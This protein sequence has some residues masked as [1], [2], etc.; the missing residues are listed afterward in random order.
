MDEERKRVI[1]IMAAILS[2]LHMQRADDL[3]ECRTVRRSPTALSRQAFSGRSGSCR[4]LI[5]YISN[6]VAE[7]IVQPMLS[8][9]TLLHG[10]SRQCR[11]RAASGSRVDLLPHDLSI[12]ETRRKMKMSEALISCRRVGHRLKAF[13]LGSTVC[14]KEP[15]G[16]LSGVQSVIQITDAR[17]DFTV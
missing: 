9:V 17:P 5:A 6:E 8:S 10:W 13:R 16:L 12:P 15:T 4:E 14:G 3:P 2:A 7:N 11:C 1:G